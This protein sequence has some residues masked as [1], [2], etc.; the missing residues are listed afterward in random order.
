MVF[1]REV[2]KFRDDIYLYLR[3]GKKRSMYKLST[4]QKKCSA[5]LEKVTAVEFD[6]VV[7]KFES[8]N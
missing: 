1:I 6:V 2:M 3:S 5:Q 7:K 8:K 4:S